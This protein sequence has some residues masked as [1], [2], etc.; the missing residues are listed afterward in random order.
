MR[1]DQQSIEEAIKVFNICINVMQE[2]INKPENKSPCS[3][4]AT[5]M[6]TDLNAIMVGKSCAVHIHNNIKTFKMTFKGKKATKPQ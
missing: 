4:N 6:R 2:Y 1:G 5:L 3:D